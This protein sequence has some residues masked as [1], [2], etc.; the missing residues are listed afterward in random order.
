MA[1]RWQAKL[2]RPIMMRDGA[3]LEVLGLEVRSN[4]TVSGRL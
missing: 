2:S 1:D 4:G 3:K